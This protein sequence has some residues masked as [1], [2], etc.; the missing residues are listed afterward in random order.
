M[1]AIRWIFNDIGLFEPLNISY[2]WI[3]KDCTNPSGP[4]QNNISL[5][6][7]NLMKTLYGWLDQ[8]VSDEFQEQDFIRSYQFWLGSMGFWSDLRAGLDGLSGDKRFHISKISKTWDIRREMLSIQYSVNLD[9]S[10]F[11]YIQ[12]ILS[13]HYICIFWSNVASTNSSLQKMPHH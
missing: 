5:R 4:D 10:T 3:S 2:Y 12:N 11:V 6:I 13:F 1:V 8:V 7:R 9:Y